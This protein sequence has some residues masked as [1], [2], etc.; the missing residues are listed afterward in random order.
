LSRRR[1]AAE[2]LTARTQEQLAEQR[3]IAAVLQQAMLPET[4]PT[5]PGIRIQASYLPG[6]VGVDIGGDWYD[7]LPLDE[8]RVFFVIGDVSGRGLAAGTTMAAL[9]FAVHAFV[10]EGHDPGEVLD[11]LTALLSVER[12]GQF[13][14]IL[15]GVFDV[16]GRTISIANAG[17]LPP[18][19]V[20]DEVRYL[21]ADGGPPIGVTHTKLYS[22]VTVPVPDDAVL[23][24]FTDGLVERRGE[25]LDEGLERLRSAI[26]PRSSVDEVFER[27][28]PEFAA[29]SSDDIAILGVQWPG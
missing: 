28:V 27:I 25:P 22:T 7:V 23:I 16:E 8:H 6:A 21:G 13:A 26:E 20:T 17:H 1:R 18:L 29:D 3:S 19:L 2:R 9:R 11:R 5:V 24:A 14:T 4:L 12:D 10:S 15:C